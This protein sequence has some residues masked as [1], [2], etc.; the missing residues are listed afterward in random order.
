[1]T[2]GIFSNLWISILSFFKL[3]KTLKK[4]KID[5]VYSSCE[6]LYD[7]LPALRLK[8]FKK[9]KWYAVYHWVE[10]YPWNDKR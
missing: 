10:E 4:E 6:H 9:S 2:P 8:L 7:V 5:I 1:V 3:P